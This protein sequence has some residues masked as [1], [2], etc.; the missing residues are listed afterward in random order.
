MPSKD[1][2]INHTFDN[3]HNLHRY[4]V[5]LE[6]YGINKNNNILE[7]QVYKVSI[8]TKGKIIHIPF[9]GLDQFTQAIPSVDTKSYMKLCFELSVDPKQMKRLTSINLL[10]S[11]RKHKLH[12]NPSK[13][14]KEVIL[15]R[16]PL[17]KVFECM[18]V[19]IKV[20][21]HKAILT[22]S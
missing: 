1:D 16:G 8:S 3:K 5:I 18:D 11:K 22:L 10:I 17:G 9:F 14:I 21:P 15:Y 2:Y 6:I 12:L 19:D 4:N 7:T 20:A 13:I